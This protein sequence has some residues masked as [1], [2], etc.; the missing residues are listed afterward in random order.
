ML[1]LEFPLWLIGCRLVAVAWIRPQE[2]PCAAAAV[3][4]TEEE[5]KEKAKTILNLRAGR[6]GVGLDL[7]LEASFVIS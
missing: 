3:I 5:D 7:A 6:K 4:N 1:K 2:L